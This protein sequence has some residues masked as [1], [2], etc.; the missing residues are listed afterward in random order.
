MDYLYWHSW[1]ARY[2]TGADI[3]QGNRYGWSF[4]RRTPLPS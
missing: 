2:V 3:W 4:I 1:N